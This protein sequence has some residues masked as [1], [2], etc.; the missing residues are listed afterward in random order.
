MELNT[1]FKNSNGEKLIG[2]LLLPNRKQAFPGIILCHGFAAHK[3]AL[4]FPALAQALVYEGFAVLRFDCRACGA[5][6]GTLHPTYK[7]MVDDLTAA[8][9]FMRRDA[10]IMEVTLI[11]H[12]MGATSC[13]MAANASIAALVLIAGVA[14]PEE[15]AEKKRGVFVHKG[16]TFTLTLPSP[17]Q[18]SFL[19]AESW[20]ADAK[21]CHPLKK[22][23]ELKLPLLLVHGNL[24][25]RIS[26]AQSKEF[27]LAAHNPKTLQILAGADHL[28]KGHE[29][30]LITAIVS[31]MKKQKKN[32][33][34]S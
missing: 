2:T 32:K 22:I 23:K 12:S 1:L 24:D 29:D 6:E 5:S 13:I 3:D 16:K 7:T 25:E 30:A 11:G 18:K 10:R 31:F 21:E 34:N 19:F 20:F 26:V 28:F 8:I 14:F 15:S 27:F 17:S 4:F 33:K 9:N